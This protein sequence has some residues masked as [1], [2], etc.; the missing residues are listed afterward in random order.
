MSLGGTMMAERLSIVDVTVRLISTRPEVEEILWKEVSP[1][2]NSFTGSIEV[3]IAYFCGK[4]DCEDEK[5][6]DGNII[7]SF[8]IYN[9][10]KNG[11]RQETE[12]NC[13]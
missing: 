7:F 8:D 3:I 11:R 10:F 9:N 12:R 2:S 6:S 4:R 13:V 5:F 1:K